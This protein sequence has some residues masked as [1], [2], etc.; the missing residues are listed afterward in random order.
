[1]GCRQIAGAA[2]HNQS[3]EF[4]S[5]LR[6]CLFGDRKFIQPVTAC[7]RYVYIANKQPVYL[8]CK[9]VTQ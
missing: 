1:M 2:R 4:R 5:V 7:T 9:F 8:A 3:F 6:H